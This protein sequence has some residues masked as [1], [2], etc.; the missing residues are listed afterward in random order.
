RCHCSTGGFPGLATVQTT[1]YA[2]HFRTGPHHPVVGGVYRHRQHSGEAYVGALV[3]K[4]RLEVLPRLPAIARAKDRAR[5][6]PGEHAIGLHR[7]KRHRPDGLAAEGRGNRL[8]SNPTIIAAV[9]AI[10]RTRDDLPRV[11]RLICEP[12]LRRLVPQALA[13]AQAFAL[14]E[15]NPDAR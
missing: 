12:T 4:L 3:G 2:V 10:M 1:A 15:R 13:R 9:D 6:R 5:A 14:V 11:L 8:E 7:V